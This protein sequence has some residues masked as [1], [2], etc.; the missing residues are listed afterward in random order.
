MQKKI[1]YTFF[2]LAVGII[3]SALEFKFA[4]AA[5][6]LFGIPIG[7]A[8]F[9]SDGFS[10]ISVVAYRAPKQQVLSSGVRFDLAEGHFTAMNKGGTVEV[11][12]TQDQFQN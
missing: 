2:A 4:V 5:F 10:T 12:P 11:M 6:L 7:L 8:I 9:L 3:F 1:V